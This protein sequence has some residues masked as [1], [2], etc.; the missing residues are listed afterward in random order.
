M[1]RAVVVLPVCR[2]PAK[3]Y[4]WASL[5]WRVFPQNM[6]DGFLAQKLFKTSRPVFSVYRETAHYIYVYH[7][8]AF[9]A[10]SAISVIIR[11]MENTGGLILKSSAFRHGD[12]IP[13]KHTC[14]GDNV[15]P[16]LEIRNIPAGA[17][18]LAVAMDD[19][20]ATRGQV[21]D[22]WVVW[23]IDPKTQYVSEDNVP[24]GAVLGKNSAG[25]LKYYGP[26]PAGAKRHTGICSKP[27][28][29]TRSW[30]CRPVQARRNWKKR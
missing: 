13:A 4:A 27:T 16:L 24:F 28:R 10:I 2:G 7:M 18:S 14:D 9:L 3:R 17:K 20:D 26:C 21:W 25:Q 29:W 12:P 15:N 30:N 22:H 1:R 8:R 6:D 23:N 5:S 19:P 11:P